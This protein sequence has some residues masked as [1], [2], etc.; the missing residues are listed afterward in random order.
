MAM[1]VLIH[2][3]GEDPIVAEIEEMP[4]PQDQFFACINPRRRDGREVS[5]LLPEIKLLLLPW[6]R[7]NCIEI[8]PSEEEEELITFVRE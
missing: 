3:M 2:L 4:A 5:Y 6:H 1:T 8:L 7:I